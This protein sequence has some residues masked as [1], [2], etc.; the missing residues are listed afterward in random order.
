M[1]I[2]FEVSNYRSIA[3]PVELSLVA[4]DASNESAR[5]VD[6]LGVSLLTRAAIFGPNASGKSNLLSGLAWLQ[7]AVRESLRAWDEGIPV[8]PF[9]FWKE[10]DTASTFALDLLVDG[11]RFEYLLELDQDAVQYEALY[12]H[13][14]TEHG[15]PSR[16]QTDN[17]GRVLVFEREDEQ[18]EFSPSIDVPQ[19]IRELM[20]PTTIV[21]SAARRLKVAPAVAFTDELQSITYGGNAPR[22]LM[23]QSSPR[24]STWPLLRLL[25]PERKTAFGGP[26]VDEDLVDQAR[27]LL[28]LADLGVEDAVVEELKP[29]I[30]ASP[31]QPRARRLRLVHIGESPDS[32]IELA[33]ESEG[34]L[35]W[36]S[37]I[38]QILQALQRGRVL[39]VDELDAS[40]HPALSAE[41]LR[42]FGSKETNPRGAQLVFST[43]DTSLFN[44]LER[45]E[46]WLTSKKPDGSTELTALAEFR[47]GKVKTT[48][49]NAYLHGRFGAVPELRET[50]FLRALG[51]IG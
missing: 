46:V 7:D 18:V 6:G 22:R 47:E 12:E 10:P 34:T 3:D 15:S 16:D 23:R 25:D 45:D 38:P 14:R 37:L 20:T 2:R 32:R 44:H 49:E 42:L 11:V 29:D 4:A 21:L 33:D 19:G 24:M 40:L 1:L 5:A 17:N 31:G 30:E 51:I 48:L 28:R 8:D 13:S 43:H 39:V 9:A 35:T 41:V 36:L 26:S 50:G 27:E